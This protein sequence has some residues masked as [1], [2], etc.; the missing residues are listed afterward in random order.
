MTGCCWQ[1]A[2]RMFGEKTAARDLKR[3]RRDGPSKPTRPLL[4]ALRARGVEGAAVLDIGGGVGAIQHELL[5]AGAARA[6]GVDAS[7]A[8]LRAAAAG[9]AAARA[10]R[11]GHGHLRATSSRWPGTSRRPTWSRSTG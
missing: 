1:G 7:P 8:Y 2:E 5:D 11:P 10:R 3:Y 4:D 9:G 6:T